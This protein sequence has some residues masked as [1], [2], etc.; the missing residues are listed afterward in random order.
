VKRAVSLVHSNSIQDLKND[1]YYNVKALLYSCKFFF[2]QINDL[3]DLA[4]VLA[5]IF[6]LRA[7]NVGFFGTLT[8]GAFQTFALMSAAE[9]A[10]ELIYTALLP[11]TVR[12][13]TR[14]KHFLP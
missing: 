14:Y 11:W 6:V 2:I 4:T 3:C 1:D 13:F 7:L 10:L 9:T 8:D 12:R 5:L